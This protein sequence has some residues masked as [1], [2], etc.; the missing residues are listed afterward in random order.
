MQKE[1]VNNPNIWFSS[2][3]HMYHTNIIKFCN[4]PFKTAHEMNEALINN[5]NEVVMPND[6]LY[7]M[8]DFGFAS[9]DRLL[10]VAG[11]LNGRKHLILGNHDKTIRKN[12]KAFEAHFESIG[13]YLEI[14][15]PDPDAKGNKQ[16]IVMFHYPMLSWSGSRHGSWALVGHAHGNVNDWHSKTTSLDVGVDNNNYYPFS[17]EQ[18]KNLMKGKEFNIVTS[19]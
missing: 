3:L 10:D 18:I 17:Y 6:K 2:D 9:R 13:D 8:G 5:F 12:L 15:C 16:R 1:K 11:R 14:W 4:R 19:I 7:I